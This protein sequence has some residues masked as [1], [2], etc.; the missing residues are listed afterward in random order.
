M[1]VHH[2]T[3]STNAAWLVTVVQGHAVLAIKCLKSSGAIHHLVTIHSL[4]RLHKSGVRLYLSSEEKLA[5]RLKSYF[6]I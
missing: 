4:Q 5:K 3:S 1:V 2:N 6:I